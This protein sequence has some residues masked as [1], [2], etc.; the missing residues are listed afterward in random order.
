MILL[1]DGTK[2]W[3]CLEVTEIATGK[4]IKIKD[5]GFDPRLHKDAKEC[6][7]PQLGSVSHFSKPVEIPSDVIAKAKGEIPIKIGGGLEVATENL[8]EIVKVITPMQRFGYL[9]SKG[10][11]N[12][13]K[14]ER[15][16]YKVLKEQLKGQI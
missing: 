5:F 4:R 8:E 13:D 11:K 6:A 3:V 14:S 10:W 9:Q 12:L 2:N 15:A 1:P 16:N 7:R